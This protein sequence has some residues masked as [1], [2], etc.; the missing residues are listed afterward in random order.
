MK[1]V[2]TRNYAQY[3]SYLH[4]THQSPNEARYVHMPEHL[5]GLHDVEVVYYGEWWLST[6]AH[7]PRLK[8]IE[9]P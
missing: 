2:I 6:I 3:Q 7:D 4:E 5:M 1:I 8:V 9:R